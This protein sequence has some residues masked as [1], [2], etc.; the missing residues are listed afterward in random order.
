MKRPAAASCLERIDELMNDVVAPLER[1]QEL[2]DVEVDRSSDSSPHEFM[3]V[4]E[5]M[6]HVSAEDAEEFHRSWMLNVIP[7]EPTKDDPKE[8]LESKDDPKEPLES[9]DDPTE[10]PLAVHNVSALEPIG[11]HK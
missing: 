2:Q 7:K 3:S 1:V 9:K 11:H 10:P 5:A 6:T 8:P 4:E